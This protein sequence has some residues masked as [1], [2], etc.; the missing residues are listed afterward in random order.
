MGIKP[1]SIQDL[2]SMNPAP[3]VTKM[4]SA[5]INLA[6]PGTYT[7]IPSPPPGKVRLVVDGPQGGFSSVNLPSNPASYLGCRLWSSDGS[8]MGP[9]NPGLTFDLDFIAQ[10]RTIS[11]GTVATRSLTG[12]DYGFLHLAP[13]ETV[14]A[15]ISNFAGGTTKV[16]GIATWMDF[17]A[18]DVTF[19]RASFPAVNVPVVL[20]PPVPVGKIAA[21][22]FPGVPN[23]P[24]NAV[25]FGIGA[26]FINPDTNTHIWDV[27]LIDPAGGTLTLA[28]YV[29][30]G[31]GPP[32]QGVQ[33]PLF[34]YGGAHYSMVLVEG[35]SLTA[36]LNVGDTLPGTPPL[37][38]AMYKL[39]DSV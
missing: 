32:T 34:N 24:G 23:G 37:I 30:V 3:W 11:H 22:Y 1:S 39:Y 33:S 7:V 25:N 13:G 9:D 5:R 18:T 10:G 20:I 29:G 21:A 38:H 15:V 6:A 8:V 27:S 16:V 36:K 17:D 19:I 14:Q 12:S 2:G 35:Q 4:G 26:T 28:S 31:G